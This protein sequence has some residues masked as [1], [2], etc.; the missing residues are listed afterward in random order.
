[1]SEDGGQIVP[2]KAVASVTT[3]AGALI[4]EC[5]DMQMTR[6]VNKAIIDAALP[7]INPNKKDDLHIRIPVSTYDPSYL[8]ITRSLTGYRPTTDQREQLARA[9]ADQ[10]EVSKNTVRKARNEGMQQ[11][12]GR[13]MTG[14]DDV[15]KVAKKYG[16][17]LDELLK[18][19]RASLA[20]G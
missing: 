15:E 8:Q 19:A 12:G 9:V 17:E 10:I 14:S 18:K 1:M 6:R 2:L 3:Q 16:T 7:G 13:N 11:L 4:V 20:K 5:F